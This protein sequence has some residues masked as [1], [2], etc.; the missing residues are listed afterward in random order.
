MKNKKSLL[1]VLLAAV[2]LCACVAGMLIVGAGAE[3]TPAPTHK[4]LVVDGVGTATDHYKKIDAA[5][6]SVSSTSWAPGST[7]TVEI[8]VASASSES[9]AKITGDSYESAIPFQISTKFLSDGSK[10]PI[11]IKSTYV[12]E[13][14]TE[15]RSK[16]GFILYNYSAWGIYFNN[17]YTFENIDLYS[18]QVQIGT[19]SSG[20][21]T[22]RYDTYFAGTGDVTFKN[23][24][25]ITSIYDFKAGSSNSWDTGIDG[26]TVNS[27]GIKFY[28]SPSSVANGSKYFSGGIFSGWLP[29]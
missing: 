25:F 16:I 21:K 1:S 15:A 18:K 17:D 4:V 10:L 14:E 20:S 23:V 7:L 5:L 24:R 26:Y 13:G 11:T 28:G 2:L 3:E 29:T 8:S 22:Y 12:A 9:L 19:S 27:R 6:K